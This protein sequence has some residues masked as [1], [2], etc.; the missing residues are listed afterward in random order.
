MTNPRRRNPDLG[1]LPGAFA[2]GACTALLFGV[3]AAGCTLGTEHRRTQTVPQP[4]SADIA[5]EVG[6]LAQELGDRAQARIALGTAR[7]LVDNLVA[8]RAPGDRFRQA[9]MEK[10]DLETTHATLRYE[11]EMALGNRVNLVGA[12]GLPG[13]APRSS[14]LEARALRTGAT[15]AIRGSF[16]RGRDDVEVSL[17]LVDLSA[18][19]VVA[20]ARRHIRNFEPNAFI[21]AIPGGGERLRA[22]A[23]RSVDG[24]QPSEVVAE[25]RRVLD[26]ERERQPAPA[27]GAAGAA[28]AAD[29]PPRTAGDPRT[30]AVEPEGTRPLEP[31]EGLPSGPI[32]FEEGPAAA[33]LRA[34]E[35]AG[36]GASDGRLGTQ[37]ARPAGT[38]PNEPPT[39]LPD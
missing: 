32:E 36:A 11:L 17:M 39:Q 33:R 28:G 34:L 1:S 29:S 4:E 7:V 27:A 19:W 30:A 8:L 16:V 10:R 13:A 23:T 26:G 12:E 37:P 38:P 15:H 2:R 18:D 20:T 3:L 31:A 14:D 24:T 6:A 21:G 25:S 35:A 9:G 22:A 5:F